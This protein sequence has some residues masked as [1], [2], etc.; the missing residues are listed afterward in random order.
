MLK[1]TINLQ[2][3]AAIKS[4]DKLRLETLRSIKAAI[5]EFEKS[6][7]NREMNSE[8][9]IRIL[10]SLVRKRKE[11]IEQYANVERND[12]ADKE[13]KEFEIIQ[14]FLPKQLTKEEISDIINEIIL[15]VE[16]KT[17]SDVGKVMGPAMDKLKGKVDGK[18]V[19]EILR[20]K[21]SSNA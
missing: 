19:F 3:K 15:T 11:A 5:I 8:E 10:S 14:E 16:A 21:L 4:R 9:E 1:E 20:A 12:L 17:L 2:L 13:R 18:T 7:L 6:S